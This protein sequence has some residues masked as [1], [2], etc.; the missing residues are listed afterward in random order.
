MQKDAQQQFY[1][2]LNEREI[3]GKFLFAICAIIVLALSL[4]HCL[5]Q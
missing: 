3:A 2:R 5:A 4:V 1:E